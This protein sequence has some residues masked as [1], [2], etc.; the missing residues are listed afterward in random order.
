MSSIGSVSSYSPQ[1]AGGAYGHPRPDPARLAEDLFSRLDTKGQGYIEKSDLESAFAGISL[2]GSGSDS[3]SVDEV[4]SQL[5][6]D[7]DGKVTQDEMTSS[8]QKLA[9]ELDS[10]FDQM[11]MASGMNG[12]GGPG[13][14]PPPPPRDDAGFSQDELESQLEEIGDTDSKRASLISNIVSNFDEADANGDG[15]VSFSEAMA[16]DRASQD[17]AGSS[18]ASATASGT[19]ASASGSTSAGVSEQAVM[20]RIMALMHAYARADGSSNGSAAN[21]GLSVSA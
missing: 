19:T 6:G 18:D 21:G 12:M 3:A 11:R 5:D 8:M 15:K 20:K 9:E 2:S 16:Y 10:Q 7:G 13:G 17:S 14:M 4:F 1:N